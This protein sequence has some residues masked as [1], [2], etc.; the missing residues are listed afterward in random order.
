MERMNL[1]SRRELL[2]SIREKY[3][4]SNLAIKIRILDGF[5]AAIGY[6]RK[7]AISL[8]N[9]PGLDFLSKKRKRKPKYNESIKRAIL[10]IWQASNQICSKRL[11]PFLPEFV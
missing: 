11:V 2:N 9:K 5:I 1:K 3:Q 10:T 8:L 4:N 7:Y 6:P